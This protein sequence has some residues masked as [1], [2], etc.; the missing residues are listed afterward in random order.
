MIPLLVGLLA[1]VP[2]QAADPVLDTL[3]DWAERSVAEL[4]IE[5]VHP[6]RASLACTDH[7][8]YTGR[9]VFGEV[10]SESGHHRRPTRI[11]VV[12]GDDGLN[13]SRLQRPER[14][15]GPDFLV[16]KVNLPTEDVRLALDRDLWLGTDEAFKTALGQW[17]FKTAALEGLGGEP[18]PPEWSPAPAVQI[19]LG[20][21]VAPVDE[22]LLR[23]IATEASGRLR[24]VDGLHHGEVEVTGLRGRALLAT[25]E[26]TRLAQ[27]MAYTAVYAWVIH[28]RDDGV[29]LHDSRAWVAATPAQLPSVDEIAGAVEAMGLGVMARAD[30]EAVPWYEGPVVFEGAAA[31]DLFRYL[32]APE[33][34][35]TPPAPRPDKTYEQLI[36]SGPRIGRR[37]LPGGWSVVSDP[38]RDQVGGYAYDR[39]GVGAQRVE[40]VEDGYVRDLAMSRIPR[41]DRR[42]SNGHAR[43]STQGSWQARLSVWTVEPRRALSAKAFERTVSKLQREAGLDR[44]LVI[45]SLQR[46]KEGSLPNPSDAVWRWA[47]GTEEPA[48]E[49]SLDKP[50][51][52]LLRDIVAAS[53]ERATSYLAAWD[54]DERVGRTT[55]LASTVI[56]PER[57]LVEEVEVVYPGPDEKPHVVPPPP[58]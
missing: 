31:A 18:P 29:S 21:E 58:L 55:G 1:A 6:Y 51:R 24:G 45:R 49:L 38:S 17:L 37:L 47:D 16:S 14:G 9:A 30:A 4:D 36:R 32:A 39:E 42:Q 7:W 43:G 11:E 20:G 56:A 10:V 26:G 8:Y 2:S 23:Q 57:V 15:R 50:G 40:L 52:R 48:L 19:D 28:V 35:G 41:H 34:Q 46:G 33:L 3:G 27:P 44:V 54:P 5:D 13:S 12:V 25:S 22:D 53:G